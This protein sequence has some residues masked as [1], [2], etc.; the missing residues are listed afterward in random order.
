[1]RIEVNR[2]SEVS[3]SYRSERARGLFNVTEED[4]S[5]FHLV[6]EIPD[7]GGPWQIGIVVGPSGS[8]KSSIGQELM[9]HGF[10]EWHSRWPSKQPVLDEIGKGSFD[11]ITGVLS[12]VGL[13]SVPAWLRPYKV[14]SNGEKFRADL[15][16]LLLHPEHKLVL[17]DEFTSVL[18]RTVAQVGSSA[19]AKTWRRQEGRKVV[20]LT[21]HYD[22]LDWVLPDWVFD[23]QKQRLF[24]E[25]DEVEANRPRTDPDPEVGR[26]VIRK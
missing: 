16:R 12:Q 13:G 2:Q 23:T 1:M 26:L 22:I 7:P 3:R 8:G 10:K 19:F 14:L 4:G 9:G 11:E 6:A 5:S 21:P 18:D 17:V 15:A 24:V 25:M 20:L